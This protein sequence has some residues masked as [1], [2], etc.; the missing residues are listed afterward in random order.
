MSGIRLHRLWGQH[1]MAADGQGRLAIIDPGERWLLIEPNQPWLYLTDASGFCQRRLGGPSKQGGTFKDPE[2]VACSPDG[3][4]VAIVD[5]DTRQ[6]QRFASDSSQAQPRVFASH[7]KGVGQLETP[8]SL[9]LDDSGMTY[10]LDGVQRK[11]SVYDAQGVFSYAFGHSDHADASDSL[12]QPRLLAVYPE[13]GAAFIYDEETSSVK[14]YALDPEHHR[15]QF[16]GSP[17]MKGSG[18]GSIQHLIGLGCDRL[19]LLYLMDSKRADI[20][21]LDT[22]KRPALVVAQIPLETLGVR[23]AQALCLA[24]DGQVFLPGDSTIHGFCW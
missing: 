16:V 18:P 17:A 1:L 22:R 8:V 10:V 20:Q 24:P 19:G 2:L 14:Q 7:G 6:V 13:G 15:A 9:C 12:H 23:K 5:T 3:A 21:V 11:V 4:S